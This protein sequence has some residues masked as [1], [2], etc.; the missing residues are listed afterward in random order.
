[1]AYRVELT[2]RAERDL[3]LLYD[4][5]QAET[6]LTANRWFDGLQ[7]AIFSLERFPFR[8]AVAPENRNVRSPIRHLLYG[9]KPHVY[10]VL[11]RVW[12]RKRIVAVVHVRYGGRDRL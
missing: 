7:R 5:I 8:C 12:E 3:A 11:F 9:R 2:A 10:R 6:S 1:M 4:Y